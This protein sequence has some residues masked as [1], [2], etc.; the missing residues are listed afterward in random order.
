[1]DG[2]IDKIEGDGQ[3]TGFTVVILR[4]WKVRSSRLPLRSPRASGA[5]R[6]DSGHAT[7]ARGAEL[8]VAFKDGVPNYLVRAK[9][10]VLEIVPRADGVALPDAQKASSRPADAV[11]RPSATHHHHH[12]HNDR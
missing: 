1:M 10:D 6:L 4:P 12:K 9:G 7:T 5:D 3:A 8:N 11:A 2:E